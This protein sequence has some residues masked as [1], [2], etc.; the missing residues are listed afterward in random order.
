MKLQHDLT[1]IDITP[2]SS[3]LDDSGNTYQIMLA[4]SSTCGAPLQHW[5]E[6]KNPWESEREREIDG[7]E[8]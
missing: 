7:D 5:E 2:S 3:E 4:A 1:F 6:D 8:K